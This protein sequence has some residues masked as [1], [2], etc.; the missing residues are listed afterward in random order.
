MYHIVLS[1]L[2][3]CISFQHMLYLSV[4]LRYLVLVYNIEQ[5]SAIKCYVQLQKLFTETYSI[6]QKAF[7]NEVTSLS[8]TNT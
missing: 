6:I 3:M 1:L 7:S 5:R 2:S 8:S 4:Y